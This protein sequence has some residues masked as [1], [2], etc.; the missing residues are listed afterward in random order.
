MWQ[1]MSKGQEKA[2]II[3]I[4]VLMLLAALTLFIGDKFREYENAA[5]GTKEIVFEVVG[6]DGASKEYD[7]KTE[8][9]NLSDAIFEEGLVS[10][11][12]H[13]AGYFTVID[14][15]EANW[16]KDK[17]WWCITVDGEMSNVGMA[18]IMLESGGHYE[19]TY[20]ID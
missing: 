2:I 20:T 7:I 12:E 18:E 16:E 6:P 3:S 11:E 8:A 17:A 5:E 10:A 1:I 19:A 4:V 13:E 9:L 15:I 14:G